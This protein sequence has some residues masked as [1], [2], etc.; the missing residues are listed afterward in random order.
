MP[1]T[2]NGK[3]GGSAG[4][5]QAVQRRLPRAPRRLLADV[6]NSNVGAT[7]SGKRRVLVWGVP[8]GARDAP[9]RRQPRRG[10]VG[11]PL[12]SRLLHI[13]MDTL[14]TTN[15]DPKAFNAVP[16]TFHPM[17]MDRMY[18]GDE[19]RASAAK[20]GPNQLFRQNETGRIYGVM[21]KRNTNAAML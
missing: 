1:K 5:C 2:K 9:V 6:E 18:E 11:V 14:K 21:I 10:T 12:V 15:S 20:Y 8:R 16:L 17:L 7:D 19:T 3:A 13:F 4:S